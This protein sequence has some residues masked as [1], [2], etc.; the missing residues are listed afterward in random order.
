MSINIYA[1]HTSPIARLFA[2]LSRHCTI[3]LS[4]GKEVTFEKGFRCGSCSYEGAMTKFEEMEYISAMM[5]M[6]I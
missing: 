4:T 1:L 2:R 3:A 5:L 6:G